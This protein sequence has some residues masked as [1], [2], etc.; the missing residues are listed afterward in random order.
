V[1][2]STIRADVMAHIDPSRHTGWRA[3]VRALA[4]LA[5]TP[6]VQVVVVFRISHALGR[7]LPT[8]PL[9]FV[10][11]S[12]TGGWGGT[13]IHPDATIGPG[14][15][16]VHSQKVIIA[17]GVTIGRDARIGH[18]VSITGDPGRGSGS[19]TLRWPVIGDEV[20]IGMD[21]IIMAGVSVGDGAVIGA[22]ALV[23]KD[24]PAG[25]VVAGSP[26]RVLRMRDDLDLPP[27]PAR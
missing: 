16:L 18:G 25:A 23:T 12:F 10:V 2:W 22:Q 26:A 8:R 27:G 1:L 7:W 19:A 15:C 24:V 5:L 9:A 20:T 4:K 6:A 13:E 3:G 21:A 17:S 14:L 11:R